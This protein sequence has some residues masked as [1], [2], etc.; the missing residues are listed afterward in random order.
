MRKYV[1]H[2]ICNTKI[3]GRIFKNLPSFKNKGISIKWK[4]IKSLNNYAVA[5]TPQRLHNRDRLRWCTCSLYTIK[6]ER[7]KTKSKMISSGWWDLEWAFVSFK[8]Y[9]IG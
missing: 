6:S 3:L 9:S 7:I 2:S 4:I 8:I 1:H 5:L